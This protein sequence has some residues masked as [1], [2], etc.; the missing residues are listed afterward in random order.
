M[1]YQTKIL[2]AFFSI[3]SSICL[4][5]N[6]PD[7]ISLNIDLNGHSTIELNFQNATDSMILQAIFSNFFP[8]SNID[9]DPL[10]FQG[11]GKKYLNLKTQMPQKVGISIS[12]V[13]PKS[14]SDPSDTLLFNGDQ[15]TTCF[16]VPNDTLRIT[17]DF[18]KREPLPRCL[19]YSGKW[20]QVSDYYKNKE[21]YFHKTD[22]IRLKA[23]TGNIAPDY[24][25]FSRIIDSLTQMELNYLKN[26]YNRSLLPKWFVDY[27]ESDIRYFSYGLKI[28]EPILM[29]GMRG[30]D[31]PIPKDYY[32]FLKECP[33]NNQ[34]AILSIYYFLSLDFYFSMIQMP[35]TDSTHKDTNFGS[36]RLDGFIT[37][38]VKNY[39]ENISDI[40][41]ALK[42]DQGINNWHVPIEVYTLYTNAIRSTDL[43]KYLERRYFNKYVLKEGDEAPDFFLKNENNESVTLK[44]FAGNIVYITF[45]FTGCKPCIKEI[46][47]EN[48]LVDV[49]KDEKVKIVSICMNSSEESWRECIEKYGIKSITLLTKGNW[50]KLLKEK[51]DINAFPQHVL[52]DKQGK[53]IMNK[54]QRPTTD[55]EQEIRKWL[56]KE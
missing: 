4:G 49:F 23:I 36:K 41:L 55:A 24:E 19:K 46:P 35:Y 16:L 13:S 22:F 2:L 3:L 34:A 26:Y 8:P 30:I 25:S 18:S 27:E 5:Q 28:D 12:F 11:S 51:Y 52:I 15:S 31:K 38:S 29:K 17:I 33:L 1:K 54:W 7:S 48:H 9:S 47:D 44:N 32:S 42:L 43:K 10:K 45:W 56:V 14:A 37:N 20:S 50:D 6:N 40:L 21:I 53:I 39:D